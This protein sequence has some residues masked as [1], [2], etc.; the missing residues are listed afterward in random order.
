[1]YRVVIQRHVQ[2]QIDRL[3]ATVGRRM[4][5]SITALGTNPRPPGCLKLTGEEQ[6]RIKV[7]KDYRVIYEINDTEVLVIVVWAGN[8]K[9]AY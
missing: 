9:D 4:Y 8:R 6:W 2:K 3:P 1:M 7:Q 5:A